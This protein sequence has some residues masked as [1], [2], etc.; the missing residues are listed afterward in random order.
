MIKEKFIL[1]IDDRRED[2][3]IKTLRNKK[4][5]EFISKLKIDL[6]IKVERTL[7]GDY[8]I[9][10][11]SLCIE[12]KA[13]PDFINSVRSKKLNEQ[14]I[15]MENNFENT[16][17]I[18]VGKLQDLVFNP[19]LR[20]FSTNQ[21]IGSI[22]SFLVR[23]RTKIYIVD[24]K[25]QFAKL[26]L[27]IAE[28]SCTDKDVSSVIRKPKTRDDIHLTMLTCVPGLGVEKAKKI[29]EK[30]SFSDI[31][32]LDEDELKEVEGIGRKLASK[33]IEILG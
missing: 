32:S 29:L 4:A 22:A 3:I 15:N 20:S 21:Y 16:Y 30:Y 31:A 23:Y 24:N 28:K 12:R 14:I 7:V 18:V 1:R 26:V 13:F 6:D 27:K 33:I 8:V 25:T 17:I 5:E 11:K 9:L 2:S 10:E 19:H